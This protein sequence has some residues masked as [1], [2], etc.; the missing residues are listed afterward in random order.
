MTDS[1]PGDRVFIV[2]GGAGS[3]GAAVARRLSE[4]GARVSLC[5][6]NA[7]KALAAELGKRRDALA[8]A[9]DVRSKSQIAEMVAQ[10]LQHF[11]RLDGLVAAAGVVSNGTFEDLEED[12]WDRVHSI[13]LKGVFLCNQAVIAPLRAN[14]FGRIVN[15]G[16]IVAHNGGNA[17]PWLG[18]GELLGSSNG[19]Y[20][21][22]KA[23]VH[24]LTMYL[25]KELAL[26]NITVN[27][28][29]PGPIASQMTT[30]LPPALT[31]QIPLQRLGRP[32]EVASAVAYLCSDE[33]T[34]ITGEILDVNGGMF[35]G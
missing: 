1:I 28:V 25:A 23:G 15:I 18:T 8:L 11:G 29:A 34:V 22:S 27:A 20:G 2:T 7:P 21:S 3:I 19:A 5:D 6:V 33:A 17:R 32:E 13:N 12:E 4:N 9:T 26:S 31:A 10:T 14:G 35:V 30:A 24:A 16:S